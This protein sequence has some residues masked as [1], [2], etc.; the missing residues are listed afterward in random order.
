MA[1]RLLQDFAEIASDWFW[2]MDENLRFSYFSSRLRE[3]AGVDPHEEIGKSRVEIARNSS[4]AAFWQAHTDDL[5]AR[6]PFRDFVYPYNHKDGRPRY[7][8]ISG[9]PMFDSEG[10]FLGY[11]GCGTDIT[12]E[13]EAI[14]RLEGQNTLFDAALNN[15]AQGL[16][17][18]D[19]NERLIVCN[20]QY[21]AL[22][23]LSSDVVRP[24]ATLKEII[25][26]GLAKQGE[27]GLNGNDLYAN[28]LVA[29]HEMPSKRLQSFRDGRLIEISYR[30]LRGGGWVATYE[31][32]SERVKIQ[33]EL[34]QQN[35]RFNTAIENM[36][37]GLC[38]FDGD[39]CLIVCNRLYA[40]MYGLTPELT[41]RGTS[42]DEILRRRVEIGAYSPENAQA[43]IEQRREV[44]RA[45][46]STNTI[47]QLSDGRIIRILHRPMPG[48]GWVATHEDVTAMV[49]QEAALRE[50]EERYRLLADHATDM[51]VRMDLDGVRQYVSPTCREVI[52]YE[53]ENLVGR[54][55]G[56]MI[57]EEDQ[58]TTRSVISRLASGEADRLTA[59]YRLRHSRGHWV[60]VEA[61]MRLI[62]HPMTNAPAG[63]VSALRDVTDRKR[64][65]AELE[66]AKA[67]AEQAAAA[68]AEFLANMSHEVR[69]PLNGILG[70][71]DLLLTDQALTGS[72]RRSIERV[73]I[74][75]SALLTVVNDVLDY[76]KIEAGEIDLEPVCFSPAALIDNALSIVNGVA[77]QRNLEL[78]TELDPLL[79]EGLIGDENRLRQV[80]LN[81]LNNA[82]KFTPQGSVTLTVSASEL[83]SGNV[84]VRFSVTDTGIGVPPEHRSRL[85]KRFSQVDSSKRREFGGTGLGLAISKRLVELMG[86]QIGFESNPDEGSTFWFEVCLERA[87]LNEKVPSCPSIPAAASGV[88]LLLAEDNEINQEIARI[89]L[90]AAGY[91]VDIV[92]DGA[93]AVGAVQS[94]AYDL[95]LMD[96]QMP[97]LDGVS[98]TSRIRALDGPQRHVPVIAMT[99][100]VLPQQVAQFRAAGMNDHVGK[101]FKRDELFAAIERWRGADGGAIR[102]PNAAA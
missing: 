36:T 17:M 34:E 12:A 58:G 87:T 39:E 85:F 86:G 5:L 22:Y 24:G 98:A 78:R 27:P 2:E 68:Q 49:R 60:W 74:A 50:S 52:G 62:R 69:T 46:K 97:I 8:K 95:V 59:T 82:V 44:V 94:K 47:S 77:A 73:Q 15:M 67:V 37:Q 6:R 11:R 23:R 101:P 91:R 3:V 71:A 61:N 7:F 48:G 93:A 57:H 100:N 65:A 40:E 54:V 19:E 66:A 89:V 38:L 41:Q 79:P 20:A 102:T 96:V 43:N 33:S 80:L 26:H 83:S 32:V 9:L 64:Q 63:I 31:D 55:P 18:F 92:G 25:N 70:Y 99:A 88:Q 13:R 30:P 4:D 1:E 29:V 14:S 42:L 56:E 90:E 21:L 76:S 53:P 51:I 10:Q 75:G 28:S 84:A 72:Q 81:L 45:N 16:A 35:T